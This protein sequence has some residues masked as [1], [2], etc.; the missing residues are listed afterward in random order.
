MMTGITVLPAEMVA[1]GYEL[2]N[3]T[4]IVRMGKGGRVVNPRLLSKEVVNPRVLSKDSNNILIRALFNGIAL[5][6]LNKHLISPW[7][8]S[9]FRKS[10]HLGLDHNLNIRDIRSMEESVRNGADESAYQDDG[11][12]FPVRYCFN[13]TFPVRGNEGIIL[14]LRVGG[15][16]KQRGDENPHKF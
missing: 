10:G 5:E 9:D 1:G 13:V 7:F 4:S 12:I 8:E 11:L 3:A 15:M 2:S 6:Y 14:R 16:V